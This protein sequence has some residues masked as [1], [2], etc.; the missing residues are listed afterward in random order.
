M[1]LAVPPAS[2][3]ALVLRDIS[4]VRPLAS[5]GDP[6]TRRLTTQTRALSCHTPGTC[7][8]LPAFWSQFHRMRSGNSQRLHVIGGSLAGQRVC[9]LKA[10]MGWKLSGWRMPRSPGGVTWGD[11]SSSQW[12]RYSGKGL[13]PGQER[14]GLIDHH[15]CGAG[16]EPGC[17]RRS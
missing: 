1:T 16:M 2:L 3:R 4:S 8:H 11:R 13:R 14:Y 15:A 12:V 7:R 9:T 5:R 17:G 10:V 6:R